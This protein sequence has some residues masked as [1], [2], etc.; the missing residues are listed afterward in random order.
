MNSPVLSDWQ[1]L[2]G[3]EFRDSELSAAVIHAEEEEEEEEE[4]EGHEHGFYLPNTDRSHLGLFVFAERE[5]NE[6]L[7]ELAV[8]I[9]SLE[10]DS[11]HEEADENASVSHDL[12][13]ISAG[14]A[15]KL[16]GNLLVGG[17]VSSTERAPS[18]VELFAEG[19]HHAVERRTEIGDTTLDKET[20]LS[21]ELYI[22]KGWNDSR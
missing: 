5:R 8:R 9:D 3:F 6:W 19:K 15:R 4:E 22:R 17:S 20:S 16:D 11:F 2:V 7:T 14:L 12:T 21:T 1:T 10:Q 13:N 18:L